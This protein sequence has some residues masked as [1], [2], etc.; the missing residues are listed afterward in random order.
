MRRQTKILNKT[1]VEYEEGVHGLKTEA[2]VAV[3]LLS[4]P[5]LHLEIVPVLRDMILTGALEEGAPVKE[6]ELCRQLGVSKTPLREA[7]KVLAFDRW[8]QLLPN[9]GAIVTRVTVE[10]SIELFELLEGLEFIVGTLAAQRV[11]AE[12][13]ETLNG[14]HF[15]LNSHLVGL[16]EREY[17]ETSQKIHELIVRT[18]HNG[19][20]VSMHEDVS[21]R[22]L[23]ARAIANLTAERRVA[24]YEEHSKILAALQSRDAPRLSIALRDHAKQ[25]GA[26]VI[27]A[28][29]R[30][31][32]K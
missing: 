10:E 26:V 17:F 21:R 2:A 5:S 1:R 23:R 22:I 13:L 19:Q 3:G 30:L 32:R 6:G 11:T 8:I 14:L 7:L 12:E 9:R 28:L 25:T 24:S 20:L 27:A 31:G 29:S 4:R 16:R 18:T 15:N